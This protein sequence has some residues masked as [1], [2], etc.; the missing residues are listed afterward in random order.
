MPL[1]DADARRAYRREHYKK[2]KA[3]YLACGKARRLKSQQERAEQKVLEDLVPKPTPK[4]FCEVCAVDISTTYK[5]KSGMK[6]APCVASYMKKYRENNAERIATL[7]KEWVAR[8]AE[9]KAEQDRRYARENPEKRRVARAKWDAKNPGA[10]SAAK[11]AVTAARKKRVPTWLSADDRW[12][13]AE[14]YDLAA[15]RTERFGFVW[16]VDHVIPMNGK[17]V[18]G[19]HVPENLQVIPWKDNLTKGTRYG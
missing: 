18:S 16:H 7:K 19:L 8:N 5:K 2:N 17:I 1:V 11:A 9:H 3:R 14:I 4:K 12:M 6:C 13:I 15:L 10:T